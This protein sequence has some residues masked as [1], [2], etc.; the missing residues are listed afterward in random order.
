MTYRVGS[1]GK[2]EGLLESKGIQVNMGTGEV[3][4]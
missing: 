1:W 3:V 2:S 4:I